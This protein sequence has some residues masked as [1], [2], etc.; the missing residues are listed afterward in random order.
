MHICESCDPLSS[1]YSA[2]SYGTKEARQ[3][4]QSTPS[5]EAPSESES[6][7]TEQ[8]GRASQD[9]VSLSNT[10]IQKASENEVTSDAELSDE[11]RQKVDELKARDT[12]VRAH[13]QAHAAVGGKYAGAPSYEYET[14]PDGKRYAVGGE[15]SIDVSEEKEPQD[16]IDKMQVVR[17]AA[18][19]PAEPSAQDLK[20]AAEATQKEQNARAELNTI[21]AD[22]DNSK[23]NKSGNSN[24]Q[25]ALETYSLIS[26]Y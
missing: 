22:Q 7:N 4:N 5:I 13:E 24:E 2:L 21:D 15:V 19:A 10:G 16:T 12:E 20:V 8:H 9:Q 26:S 23:I 17:A 3:D 18:L 1:Q 25:K 6:S 14:G 11:E